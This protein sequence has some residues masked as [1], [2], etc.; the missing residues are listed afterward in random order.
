MSVA[1]LAAFITLA[2]IPPVHAITWAVMRQW[3]PVSNRA[4][5]AAEDRACTCPGREAHRVR[6]GIRPSA[7]CGEPSNLP[8]C[9]EKGLS[10]SASGDAY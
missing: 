8:S 9:R 7:P 2:T 10:G 1:S 4:R 3:R 5:H 6:I